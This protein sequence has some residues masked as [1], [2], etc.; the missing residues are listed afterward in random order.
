MAAIDPVASADSS[1]VVDIEAFAYQLVLTSLFEQAL[2]KPDLGESDDSSGV[3]DQVN[4]VIAQ[5]IAKG[6][7][8]FGQ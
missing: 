7:T 4:R 2:K 3:G 8:G 6:V 1:N 5:E